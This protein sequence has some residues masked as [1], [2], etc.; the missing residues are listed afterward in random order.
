MTS[1]HEPGSANTPSRHEPSWLAALRLL[2]W[3]VVIAASVILI[4]AL[5]TRAC[6]TVTR[7]GRAAFDALKGGLSSTSLTTSFV[8]S[9]PHLVPGSG[10]TLELAAVESVE[11]V[12]RSENRR[13]FFDLL[14]LGTTVTEIRVPVTYRYHVRLDAPW[15]LDVVGNACV[16]HAPALEPTLPPAIHTDRMEKRVERSWLQL[17]LTAQMDALE[18]S[19][20]PT[21]S[22]RARSPETVAMV[23]DLCRRRLAE[24]VRAWLLRTGHWQDER[25][26]T[27]VVRFAD[28]PEAVKREGPRLK[29]EE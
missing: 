17:D 25:L 29:S 3:P 16:V 15:R 18:R 1:A 28:E 19:L 23:R 9:L 10:T 7:R 24:F 12:T 27:V 22:V 2:R 4:V 8:A 20:T 13:L 14:S 5:G 21:L 26:T 11:T 6:D